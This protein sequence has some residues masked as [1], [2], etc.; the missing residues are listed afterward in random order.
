MSRVFVNP[1]IL[2]WA[3]QRAGLDMGDLLPKFPKLQD[4]LE[5]GLAP[6]LKQ[7]GPGDSG[8]IILYSICKTLKGQWAQAGNVIPPKKG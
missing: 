3:G 5:G 7:L 2:N 6:T 1:E 4:W 8:D